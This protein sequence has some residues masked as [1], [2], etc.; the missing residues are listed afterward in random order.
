MIVLDTTILSYA[1]GSEHP[2][3]DP[4]R[5]LL[6]AHGDGLVQAATTIEVLQ[7]FTHVRARRRSREDAVALAREYAS[8]LV[9]LAT[10][11]EDLDL[12]LT[13][14]QRYPGLGAFDA[15]LA[16]V[17]LNRQARAL[18]SADRTFGTVAGPRWIDP[19]TPALDRLLAK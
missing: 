13:L 15:M 17:A 12:G 14:F 4:C 7:E 8:A 18:V 11:I 1:V 5:W 9:V 3:R 2:L 10:R 6:V 19:T 16:A